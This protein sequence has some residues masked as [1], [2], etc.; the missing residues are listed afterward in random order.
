MKNNYLS[1]ALL[2]CVSYCFAAATIAEPITYRI[3]PSHTYPSFEADHFAGLS[4]WRGKVNSTSGTVVMDREAQTG[5]VDITMDMAT[6][7]FGHEGMNAT[8]I[9]DILEVAIFPTANYQGTLKGFIEGE[10]TAVEGMLTMHGITLPLDLII[11]RFR[12]QPHHRSGVELCGAD[13]STTFDRSEYGL[14]AD[15]HLGFFPEVRLLI[16]LEARAVEPE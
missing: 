13:A 10:P 3:D 7:D 11:D 2:L 6:I 4:I 15:L 1:V 16:S 14:D 9:N 8:A 5:S 12:C